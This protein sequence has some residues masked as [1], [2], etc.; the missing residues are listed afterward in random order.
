VG[1]TRFRP[2]VDELDAMGATT[3]RDVVVLSWPADQAEA[4]RLAA[5]DVPKLLLVDPSADPPIGDDPL[6]EWIRLPAD[7]RDV[8]ARLRLLRARSDGGTAVPTVDAHG[9]LR[10]RGRWVALS[11]GEERLARV[12][13]EQFDELVSDEELIERGWS[14]EQLT[15]GAFRLQLHRLRRRIKP[16]GLAIRVVRH[17]GY[18]MHL[19]SAPPLT[20]SES[21]EL[22]R[23]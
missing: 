2:V 14:T 22:Q 17:R 13:A 19:L 7:D 10:F 6:T 11:L 23:G 5:M 8:R 3:M 12:L 15:S 1:T 4:A 18:S 20:A 9:C 16:L 21:A